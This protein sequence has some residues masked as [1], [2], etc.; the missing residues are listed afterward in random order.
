[1]NAPFIFRRHGPAI[2]DKPLRP[3][4][5]QSFHEVTTAF[6]LIFSLKAYEYPRTPAATMAGISAA[7]NKKKTAASQQRGP[8]CV[9]QNVSPWPLRQ[10]SSR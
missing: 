5:V 7:A 6:L 2:I 3:D 8:I 4:N 1:M 9:F 10:P